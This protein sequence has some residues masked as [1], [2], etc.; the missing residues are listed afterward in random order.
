MILINQERLK[1]VNYIPVYMILFFF[2]AVTVFP[3]LWVFISSF[4][5]NAELMRTP[6]SWP[7]T[8]QFS[9]YLKAFEVGH[10]GQLFVNSLFVSIVSTL[11]CLLFATM[12]AYAV[13]QGGKWSKMIYFVIILGIFLPTN[14][15]LV[16][17]YII[18]GKL[19]LINTLW[20]LITTYTAMGLPLTLLLVYGFLQ[21]VPNEILE[22]SYIDGC[23]FFRSYV[24]V[25]LP[26]LK[27]GMATAAIF[28]FIFCWNEFIFSLLLTTSQEMRTLQVGISMFNTTFQSD[29]TTMFAA[30]FS[31][32][33]PVIIIYAVLQKHIISGLAAGAVKG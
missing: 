17:Y 22:A 33:L 1:W 32:V 23:N 15:L 5:T 4:K 19:H 31:S 21:R 26:L 3:F 9:N 8:F 6:F 25:V 18:A 28:Q 11:L 16:P 29:Y 13:R 12:A 24:R 27:S 7:E 20:A 14:A 10:L 2:L 30:V